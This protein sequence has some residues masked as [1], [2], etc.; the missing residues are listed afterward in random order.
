MESIFLSLRRYPS[1][2]QVCRKIRSTILFLLR[3]LFSLH[4]SRATQRDFRRR[5]IAIDRMKARPFNEIRRRETPSYD[6]ADAYSCD[7]RIFFF[8]HVQVRRRSIY[9]CYGVFSIFIRCR[10]QKSRR[11]CE[12][13]DAR[14]RDRLRFF[15]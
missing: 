3:F 10:S 4:A 2:W 14:N 8:F 13:F 6:H 12:S 15:P 5:S 11:Y 7:S 9:P 1:F